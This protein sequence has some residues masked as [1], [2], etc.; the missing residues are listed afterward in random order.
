MMKSSFVGGD[1]VLTDEVSFDTPHRRDVSVWASDLE[2]VWY[3]HFYTSWHEGL[4]LSVR[5]GRFHHIGEYL[6]MDDARAEALMEE[7]DILLDEREEEEEEWLESL[8]E[9]EDPSYYALQ[10]WRWM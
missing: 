7:L 1:R 2:G 10:D 9:G 6:D 8:R 3:V 4:W 5:D